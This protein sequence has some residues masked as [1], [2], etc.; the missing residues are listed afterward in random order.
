MFLVLSTP[1]LVQ[2][3]RILNIMDLEHNGSDLEHNA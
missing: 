2:S 3:D 1:Q